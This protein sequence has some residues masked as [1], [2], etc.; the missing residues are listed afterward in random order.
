MT[1][2]NVVVGVR[3]EFKMGQFHSFSFSILWL[4]DNLMSRFKT[5]FLIHLFV[6]LFSGVYR[7]TLRNYHFFCAEC[8]RSPGPQV[9]HQIS[10]LCPLIFL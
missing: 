6:C 4:Q 1:L 3:G 10:H 9:S 8:S 2:G 5:D 7:A